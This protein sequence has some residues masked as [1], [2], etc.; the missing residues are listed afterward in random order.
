M[1]PSLSATGDSRSIEHHGF[2][3]DRLNH[4]ALGIINAPHTTNAIITSNAPVTISR[5]VRGFTPPIYPRGPPPMA[6]TI[7]SRTRRPIATFAADPAGVARR[8]F[9]DHTPAEQVSVDGSETGA[10]GKPRR[11]PFPV[12]Y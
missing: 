12:Q 11:R 3:D 2:R 8:R 10:A 1:P 6:R 7:G 9:L 5:R 4:R